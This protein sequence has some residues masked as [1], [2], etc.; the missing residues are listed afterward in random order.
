MSEIPRLGNGRR[1]TVLSTHTDTP[2]PSALPETS[3]DLLMSSYPAVTV[4]LSGAV[5]WV[6]H[7]VSTS[8]FKGCG[9]LQTRV[10]G[11]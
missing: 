8:L 9:R 1:V 7:S 6:V 5:Q 11:S 3:R 2:T 10:G 4:G